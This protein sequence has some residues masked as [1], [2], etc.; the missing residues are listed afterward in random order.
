VGCGAAF[1]VDFEPEPPPERDV[2]PRAGTDD[3][4]RWFG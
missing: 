2:L 4:E 3:F 1:A